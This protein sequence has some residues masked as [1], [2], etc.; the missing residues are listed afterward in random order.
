VETAGRE[1]LVFSILVNDFPGRAHNTIRAIDAVGSALAAAGGNPA[2]LGAAVASA[3]PPPSTARDED[4]AD[5]KAHLATYYQLGRA[6]DARNVPFLRTALQ[7]ERDPVLRVVAAE[8]V[9]L[10]EPD[11]ESGRRAFLDGVAADGVA[12]FARL[13]ALGAGLESPAPVLGSLGDLA[14]EGVQEALARLIE[15]TPAAAADPAL[16]DRMGELWEDVARSAPDE[17]VRALQLAPA[18]AA[19]ASI[20]AIARGVAGAQ[21]EHPLPAA[22]RRAQADPDGALAAYA[23][24]LAPRFDEQAAA[25][26]AVRQSGPAV[27]GPAAK[28]APPAPAPVPTRNDG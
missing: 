10:S 22:I 5:V 6:G 1:R 7:T 11:S 26:R 13:R 27:I 23:R 19:D 9:Y 25:A 24:T 28:V 18:A 8:A 15:L 21:S 2:D 20:A 16:S 3:T 12:S 17:V 4:A 14:A